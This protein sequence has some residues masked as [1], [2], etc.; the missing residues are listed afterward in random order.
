MSKDKINVWGK[1]DESGLFAMLKTSEELIKEI[2]S[3]TSKLVNGVLR[4]LKSLDYDELMDWCD[5]CSV[6][7]FKT[8]EAIFASD[9]RLSEVIRIENKKRLKQ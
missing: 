9:Y 8:F 4:E 5:T 6:D 1:I 2:D 7:E 3:I